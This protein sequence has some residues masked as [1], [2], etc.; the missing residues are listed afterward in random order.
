M[1]P[2]VKKVVLGL[3]EES[4]SDDMFFESRRAALEATRDYILG[5]PAES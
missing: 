1:N 2:E 4:V 3:Q 5:S